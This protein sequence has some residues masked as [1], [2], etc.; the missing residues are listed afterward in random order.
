[1]MFVSMTLGLLA[2]EEGGKFNPLDMA[3]GGNVLWTWVIFGVALIFMWK[4]VMAPITSALEE[5]DEN[6][7]HAIAAAEKAR[8]DAEKARADV[9]VALGQ[10][11]AEAATLLAEARKRAEAREHEIVEAA[12]QEAS[13]MVE[14][15]RKA[16][17]AEQD[18]AIST[19]RTEVVDLTLHAASKVLE[20]TV[21][22]ED[23][24]RFV[25]ELVS[26]QDASNN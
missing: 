18:K 3:A 23:D 22:S 14:T 21:E 26:G 6:A 13:Q 4:V 5:R 20:R 8:H 1:M 7:A 2:A 16:I 12:K 19:I 9:E 17:R 15:A 11:Q 10:A 24:R 25:A